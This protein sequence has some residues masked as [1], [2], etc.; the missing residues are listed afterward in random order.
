MINSPHC[1]LMCSSTPKNFNLY[2]I[3]L[4]ASLAVDYSQHVKMS[5]EINLLH[6]AMRNEKG[7]F[8]SLLLQVLSHYSSLFRCY[9]WKWNGLQYELRDSM[10][11]HYSALPENCSYYRNLLEPGV[12][13]LFMKRISHISGCIWVYIVVPDFYCILKAKIHHYYFLVSK[14]VGVNLNC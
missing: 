12:L 4:T 9:I 2:S 11:V 14:A 8:G 13:M 5:K 1:K 6:E 7:L 10:Q 3:L